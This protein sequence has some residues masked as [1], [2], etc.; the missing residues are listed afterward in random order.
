MTR[1]L[2]PSLSGKPPPPP[3]SSP[4]A[5]RRRPQR[6]TPKRSRGRVRPR[7]IVIGCI[8]ALF[9]LP[10][11]TILLL[12]WLPPPTSAFML[13]SPV[14][15]VHYRWVAHDDISDWM[16]RAVVAS[17]DQRFNEHHGFDFKA[18]EQALREYGDGEPLRGAST[19]SQQTAK[20]LFLWSGGGFLRKG[21]EAMLTV[22]LE[23]MW[24]KRRIL[25][26]YLNIAEFGPG[27]FGVEAAAH[28]CCGKSAASLTPSEAAR[29]A[30]VL[31]SP[32]RWDARDP[33]SYVRTRS[34][35]I[36][37]QMGAVPR[38][39]QPEI[40]T[41]DPEHPAT[42]LG[43]DTPPAT[44]PEQPAELIDQT[45]SAAAPDEAPT[46]NAPTD[47]QKPEPAPEPADPQTATADSEAAQTVQEPVENA[48]EEPAHDTPEPT[49]VQ[50]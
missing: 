41:P 15:P 24:P 16:R 18:I 29:L 31:P 20:N 13:H 7:D 48:P 11:L 9:G 19:I 2:E 22:S 8:L 10:L 12:R 44:P 38:H 27:I 28:W 34:R 30:A 6:P 17:E 49:P 33:G 1:R 25:D 5:P 14:K 47:A 45:L 43:A 21:V 36:L 26:V 32:R 23:L 40:G 4:R 46:E 42:A 37:E 35:W 50:L 39:A 3:A